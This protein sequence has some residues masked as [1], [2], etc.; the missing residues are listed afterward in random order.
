MHLNDFFVLFFSFVFTVSGFYIN[1]RRKIKNTEILKQSSDTSLTIF[2]ICIPMALV[3]SIFL[4][5]TKI[6][7]F[8]SSKVYIF[9]GYFFVILGLIIRWYAV[10]TLGKYFRVQLTI[11]KNQP[12]LQEGIYKY[13]RHP[14]YTGLLL[15]YLG[16]G[17]IMHNYYSL[18]LLTSI[19]FYVVWHRITIEEKFL[20]AHF[21]KTYVFYKK[22]TY[23]LFPF[24]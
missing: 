1:F 5:F 3:L 11:L 16:L 23:K 17:L 20:T 6:G 12:L 18:L 14:S 2:R 9:L 4:Y 10:S 22:N 19:P 21:G 13:I 8:S 15:Y 7:R 24:F